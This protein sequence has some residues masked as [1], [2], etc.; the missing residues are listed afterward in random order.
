MTSSSSLLLLLLL[1]LL[2]AVHENKVIWFCSEYCQ[3]CK[4]FSLNTDNWRHDKWMMTWLKQRTLT[5]FGKASLNHC[6]ADLLFQWFWIWPNK[7]NML[8]IQQKQS[9][10]I[11][12]LFVSPKVRY[13]SLTDL[14]GSINVQLTSWI[15]I[16]IQLLCLSW[17]KNSFTLLVK[18]KPV[19]QLFSRLYGECALI[20]R[21]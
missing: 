18:S 11:Q 12:T 13:W 8:L 10:L 3:C 21:E 14:S 20:I 16:R 19:K 17:I 7:F 2:L 1:L 6:S 5:Y 4:T 15:F 9:S